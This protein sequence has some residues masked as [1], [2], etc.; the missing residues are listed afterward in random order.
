M[1]V[2]EARDVMFP[3][4]HLATALNVLVAGNVVE[5]I[6]VGQRISYRWLGW[7]RT[8]AVAQSPTPAPSTS[9]TK[10]LAAPIVTPIAPAPAEIPT[11]TGDTMANRVPKLPRGEMRE[12]IRKIVEAHPELTNTEIARRA[13]VGAGTV[14]FHLKKLGIPDSQK[15][16]Q[17]KKPVDAR[18]A[19]RCAPPP[20]ATAPKPL[21]AELDRIT[22]RLAPITRADEKIALLDRLTSIG[23]TAGELV[24]EIR[25]DIA[26]LAA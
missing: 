13:G 26:R 5:E 6:K 15:N 21:A 9:A 10:R 20:R 23:G 7:N 14:T 12:R 4:S 1:R 19:K 2:Q 16:T 17:A 24:A 18:K 8:D 25:S 22:A 3:D 11:A